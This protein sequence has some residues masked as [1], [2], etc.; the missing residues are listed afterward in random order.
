MKFD[1]HAYNI[2][3]DEIRYFGVDRSVLASWFSG[4]SVTI[5]LLLLCWVV[6][7]YY[8]A[9]VW[10]ESGKGSFSCVRVVCVRYHVSI[11]SD[12]RSSS[13]V[14]QYN[15]NSRLELY[16]SLRPVRGVTGRLYLFRI[17]GGWETL[18]TKFDILPWVLK[19]PLA[20]YRTLGQ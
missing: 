19:S 9:C 7:V 13:A 3:F 10:R 16:S 8:Y 6:F 17:W 15:D 20:N 1:E 12:R 4:Q 5:L 18:K 11:L 14:N 2:Y